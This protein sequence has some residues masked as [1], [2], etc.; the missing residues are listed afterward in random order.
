M[1]QCKNI[2]LSNQS[3]SVSTHS[4]F[5]CV[6]CTNHHRHRCCR[7]RRHRSVILFMYFFIQFRFHFESFRFGCMRVSSLSF[8]SLLQL[9]EFDPF[10]DEWFRCEF[11]FCPSLFDRYSVSLVPIFMWS[12][13]ISTKSN[14]RHFLFSWVFVLVQANNPSCRQTDTK[15]LSELKRSTES[16]R[17]NWNQIMVA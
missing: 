12:P 8:L 7:C 6:V 3:I 5:Y 15:I 4:T 9:N 14:C 10:I 13:N 17:L 1:V 16:K 11:C 2:I